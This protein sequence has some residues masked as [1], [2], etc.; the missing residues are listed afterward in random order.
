M[1]QLVINVKNLK[2]SNDLPFILIAGPDSIESENHALFMAGEIKRI[3]TEV[4]VPYIFKAS[5]DKANRTSIK[6][7]RGVGLKKGMEILSEV[8]KQLKIPV[9]TDVHSVEQAIKVGDIVDLIQIP[10]FLSRQT[11]LLLAAG[12]TGKPVN[13]KKGP[14]IAPYDINNL[15]EK[16][17]STR[18]KQIMITERGTIFGYNNVVADMRSLEIMKR[19]HYP[20]IFDASH[21]VQLPSGLQNKSGG[22]RSLIPALARAAIAVSIAGIFI[23]VHNDPDNAPVDGLNSL[24]LKDLPTLLKTLKSID[25]IVK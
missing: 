12:K 25:Q 22:D 8:K 1:E 17:I 24:N 10:S 16:V 23:E 7:F 9:T 20:V 19:F 2:I 5:Y 3:T 14:F 4:G 15:I 21:T 6:S 18:N 11:D 13:I